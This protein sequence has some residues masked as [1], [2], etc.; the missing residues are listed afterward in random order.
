[1]SRLGTAAS[2]GTP[3]GPVVPGIPRDDLMA[4]QITDL[5]LER[6]RNA[7][8]KEPDTP[9]DEASALLAAS[10]TF[11]RELGEARDREYVDLK[12][13][14]VERFHVGLAATKREL[15][16]QATRASVAALPRPPKV[17]RKGHFSPRELHRLSPR[18]WEQQ[19]AFKPGSRRAALPPSPQPS[20]PPPPP[21]AAR[22]RSSLL[23]TTD[24]KPP[25]LHALPPF[26]PTAAHGPSRPPPT[27][28]PR[29]LPSRAASRSSKSTR[30]TPTFSPSCR[31]ARRAGCRRSAPG[32][33]RS[34]PRAPP[35]PPW[36]HDGCRRATCRG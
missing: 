31:R 10:Q 5:I 21:R 36:G 8:G 28:P 7:V 3:S 13:G 29:P 18:F 30:A 15:D 6:E 35:T 9:R 34:R 25:T 22:R 12:D 23:L 4:A 11:R 27:A 14:Y 19:V 32:Y 17:A 20:P 24:R 1:M 33:R 26:L 2:A 16:G